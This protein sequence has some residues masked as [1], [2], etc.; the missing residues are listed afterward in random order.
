MIYRNLTSN[1]AAITRVV[2]LA[3]L[4]LV[5]C[6]ASYPAYSNDKQPHDTS[7]QSNVANIKED[8]TQGV[9]IRSN[10]KTLYIDFY[11]S[12]P[13]ETTHG[14]YFIDSDNSITTGFTGSSEREIHGADYLIDGFGVY[15]SLSKSEWKWRYIGRFETFKNI[16]IGKGNIKKQIKMGNPSFD[17]SVIFGGREF[18]VMLELYDKNW[19]K[20]YSVT[21]S[22]FEDAKVINVRRFGAIGDGATDDTQAIRASVQALSDNDTL[23]FPNGQYL[24]NSG[25]IESKN[26]LEILISNKNNITVIGESSRSTI[27]VD[28]QNSYKHSQKND[29]A[30]FVIKDS[31]N[32]DIS[33]LTFKSIAGFPA[34]SRSYDGR[35]SGLYCKGVENLHIHHLQA[36]RYSNSGVVI[37]A[38]SNVISKGIRVNSSKL[39]RNRVAGLLVGSAEDVIV[40][41]NNFSFNGQPG[42]GGT[43][44]GFA[45]VSGSKPIRVIVRN[46]LAY[47][48]IRKGIDFHAG[49]DI[50]I[51]NNRVQGNGLYGIDVEGE[52]IGGTI[53]IIGNI[54]SDMNPINAQKTHAL[55]SVKFKV[56]RNRPNIAAGG[57]NYFNTVY[58]IFFYLPKEQKNRTQV[59]IRD[60]VVHEFTG[61]NPPNGV[62]QRYY[63]INVY[64]ACNPHDNVDFTITGNKFKVGE[65]YN[66]FNMSECS[67][68]SGSFS[69]IYS[70]NTFWYDK[71]HHARVKY[72]DIS[73][74]TVTDNKFIRSGSTNTQNSW[75]NSMLYN[76][77]SSALKALEI[78]RN[79][80]VK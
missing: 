50:Q 73:S 66:F 36:L 13:D 5:G 48:N 74:L 77:G 9:H 28:A 45:G 72:L 42:D 46:N 80:W 19:E 3:V 18:K 25:K 33:H 37:H 27:I 8:W 65:I 51:L 60:N 41:D 34:S 52:N 6:G 55:D 29:Y 49:Y 11:D 16:Q 40:E 4:F 57:T 21:K 10:L 35:L 14:Q 39:S 61:K 30:T 43:G 53:K 75:S 69:L 67:S 79:I 32:V 22:V 71:V 54:I 47:N 26:K 1:E 17:Y 24:V 58:G 12:F 62:L 7:K 64:T 59:E 15:R 23:Y 20:I 38:S 76:T 63:P 70:K 44:Y 78:N 31:K 56:D 2:F 68:S